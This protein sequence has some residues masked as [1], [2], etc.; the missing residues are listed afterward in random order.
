MVSVPVVSVNEISS[1][2]ITFPSMV[3]VSE[4]VGRVSLIQLSGSDQM[5]VAPP[6]S[7]SIGR[8]QT[9]LVIAFPVSRPVKV[10]VGVAS[11]QLTIEPRFVVLPALI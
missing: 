3:M 4:P 5:S 6:P 7:Q 10:M 1:V 8:E 9:S 2:T 11:V